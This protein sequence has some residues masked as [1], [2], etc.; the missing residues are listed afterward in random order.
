M[1]LLRW[2]PF[3]EMN[4]LF[5]RLPSMSGRWPRIAGT[6]EATLWSP[7]ADISESGR[8]YLIRATLPSVKKED[9]EVTLEDGVLTLNGERR[10]EEEQKVEE[11][12]RVET[13]YGRFSRSFKLPEAIDAT[14]IRA[15]T[16][17]G[18]LTIHVPKLKA[19]VKKPGAIKVQ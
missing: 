10:H 5:N 8:E 15:E 13:F 12:H 9:V 7:P 19:E 3:V 18:V 16:K 2:E 1:R 17:D 11:F 14:A 4:G 6:A